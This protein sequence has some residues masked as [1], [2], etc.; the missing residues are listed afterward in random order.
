MDDIVRVMKALS[1]PGRV[2]VMK[3]L[4]EREL[5]ACEIIRAL[6][7]AQPTVSRHMR[8]LGDAGLVRARR[9]AGWVHYSLAEAPASPVAR[10]MLERLA[11]WLEDDP[12]VLALR[13]GLHKADGRC[14]RPALDKAR[15]LGDEDGT[16]ACGGKAE[17]V[18]HTG[19]PGG[20]H[21]AL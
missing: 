6:G 16:A 4:G 18:G 21:E 5:C 8:V 3:L 12:V 17:R 9:V 10:A 20:A 13:G 14:A 15:R 7:L 1:D 2:M 19:Q 11:C